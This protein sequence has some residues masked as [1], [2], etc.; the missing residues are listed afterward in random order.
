MAQ[1]QRAW[2]ITTRSLDRN[3]LSVLNGDGAAGA[4]GAHNSEVLGSSPSSRITHHIAPVHQGTRAKQSPVAQRQSVSNTVVY[5]QDMQ[6][7][8]FEDGYRLISGRSQDRNLSGEFNHITSHRCIKALEQ[9]LNRH[10]AEAARVA[11]NH[12]VTRSKRVVGIFYI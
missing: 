1:R 2:L 6:M 12:E 9:P 3:G 8:E 10:G 4:R 5:H 7:S 11:H